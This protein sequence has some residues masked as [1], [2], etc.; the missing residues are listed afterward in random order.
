MYVGEIAD[1]MCG[2]Q[3][4]MLYIPTPPISKSHKM[5]IGANR[6]PIL[7][8]PLCCSVKRQTNIAHAE[9]TGTSEIDKRPRE[10]KSATKTSN[11][12]QK[13]KSKMCSTYK[14]KFDL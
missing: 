9:G 3:W 14:L 8:L 13:P 12:C 10:G 11:I 6:N 4:Q 2:S 1:M 7:W 5:T